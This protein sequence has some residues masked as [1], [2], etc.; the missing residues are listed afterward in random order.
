MEGHA[1]C[2]RKLRRPRLTRRFGRAGKSSG[3]RAPVACLR[4]RP[5]RT[6]YGFIRPRP[7]EATTER[8]GI[9]PRGASRMDAAACAAMVSRGASNSYTPTEAG[10]EQRDMHRGR[11]GRQ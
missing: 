11:V 2:Q 4:L 3:A 8:E 6:G 10:L 5:R 7:E 1:N 9:D